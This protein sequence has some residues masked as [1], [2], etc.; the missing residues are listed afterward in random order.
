MS[1]RELIFEIGV[2]EIPSAPLYA[3]IGQLAADA[4]T[5]LAAE[6]LDFVTVDVFGSPRRLVLRVTDLAETQEDRT[7]R[8]KGPATKI[9]FD[10]EG[11]PTKAA[12]G[13]ARGQGVDVSALERVKDDAGEYI[14]AVVEQ[15]GRPTVEVLPDL[16][17]TLV[18]GI[19]WPK[20]MRWGSGESRF[21][22]PVRWLL[23]LFGS[24]VAPVE[25]AG[26]TAGRTTHGHRFL[27]PGPIEL[28]SAAEYTD[29]MH[30]G[31]VVFDH[32]DRAARIREGVEVISATHGLTPVVS[33]KVFSEVV[34]LVEWPT[35][36]LGRFDEEFLAVPREVLT[37]AM[38]SHQRY[39]PTEGPDGELSNA[40]VVVHNGDPGR[41]ETIVSGHERVIRA[42]LADAA[43]FYREDLARPIEQLVAELERIVF[44]E[45]LGTLGAKVARLEA[46]VA[47]L[48]ELSEADPGAAAAA[49]RAAHLAKADLVSHAVIEFPG[50][51][52]IMGRYYALA[53]G[54][55]EAV[56]AAIPEHYQPRFAGDALPA[57]EAGRLVSAADKL[58]TICGIFAI[59][60][61]PTGSADPYALRRGALGVLNIIIDGL[62]IT[63]DEAIGAALD[64]YADSL[65]IDPA[66]VGAQVKEFIVGR[67]EG[68]LRDRGH[69]YDTVAAVLAVA[70]DDPADAIARADALT[71]MR[72]TTDAMDDLS[73]AFTR[74]RNLSRPELGT[75][76]DA[77]L[78]GAEEAVLADALAEAE[79]RAGIS[80]TQGDY[81]AALGVLASLRGPIDAFFDAV[82]VMDPDE[83]LRDNRLRQLNR[84]VALFERFADF[85]R[86]AG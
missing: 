44:Q 18:S 82:L 39:F 86:L 58:D 9:A 78:M 5:L 24:E 69:A 63:L 67:F 47:R 13:F 85:G 56:A 11:N 28:S 29:A 1:A 30:A 40:F 76:A 3:A 46:L 35:V 80:L 70:A 21:T 83:Q 54:E 6:R 34:N 19:D 27:A 72:A 55:S 66:T 16:L 74:A 50:L 77:S 37:T 81:P 25:F 12:E 4:K 26:L 38:E 51:Q 23:A 68:V 32:A 7:S 15:V 48:S 57:S 84:F 79:E 52:G 65:D 45:R 60:M 17:S 8:V 59:G 62:G 71:A 49:A 64:G 41:T 2:E 43:F 31:R 33:E 36:G 42:R 73:V 53:A 61:A 75:D 10:A 14:Y 20:S 22:R